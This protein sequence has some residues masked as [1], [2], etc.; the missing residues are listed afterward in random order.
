MALQ[1][2]LVDDHQMFLEGLET[3]LQR[4]NTYYVVGKALDGLEAIDFIEKNKVD[5][6]VTDIN[7]PNMSGTELTKQIKEKWPELKVL[8]LS[9]YNDREI[10]LDILMAEADGYILKNSGKQEL[11]KALAHISNGGTYYSNEVIE[12]I[13]ENFADEKKS[14][15]TIKKLT[16]RE[17]E[18]L[19]LVCQEL[20][21]PEIAEKLCISHFT[22]ETHRKNILRKTHTKTIVGLIKYAISNGIA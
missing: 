11:L 22:V 14:D 17:G 6:V 13:S 5:I 21:T 12:I 3:L 7:M 18:I 4:N 16:T 8:V 15:G 2:L 10:I 9:M 1:V 19:K 20:S